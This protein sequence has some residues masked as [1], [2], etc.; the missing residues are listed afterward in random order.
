MTTNNQT[1]SNK[2]A[3]LNAAEE[4]ILA[5]IILAGIEAGKTPRAKGSKKLIRDGE[6]ARAHF[7]EA[8]LRLAHYVARQYI[9][10]GIDY[11]DLVQ[12]ATLGLIHAI[13]KFDPTRGYRFSTYAIPWLRQYVSRY[14]GNHS[15]SVRLPLYQIEA[16]NKLRSAHNALV[17][18]FNVEPTIEELSVVTGMDKRKIQELRNINQPSISMDVPIN[19]DGTGTYGDLVP[20]GVHVEPEDVFFASVAEENIISLFDSLN[21]RESTILKMRFGFAESEPLSLDEVSKR[22][23]I[24][25]ERVRKIERDALTKLRHPSRTHG[26]LSLIS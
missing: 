3:L 25:K 14:I 23:N 10:R 7:I 9:G 6:N 15:R 2:K 20:A 11:E 12:E 4:I 8:N 22:L 13:S 19:E 17:A 1:S 26:L 18:E 21:D 24:T 5:N 16:L